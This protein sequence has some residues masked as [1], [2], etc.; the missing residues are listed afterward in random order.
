[1]KG[2][3]VRSPSNPHHTSPPH[4]FGRVS[5][6]PPG[7]DIVPRPDGT[8]LLRP[9][10]PDKLPPDEKKS[11]PCHCRKK[12]DLHAE[13][14]HVS[15]FHGQWTHP[16]VSS[17]MRTRS[18]RPFKTTV[19]TRSGARS[20]RATSRVFPVTDTSS[21][22]S[23]CPLVVSGAGT[24]PTRAGDSASGSFRS[25]RK[26]SRTTKRGSPRWWATRPAGTR[27]PRRMA[28]TASAL[29]G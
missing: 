27:P 11:G 18:A 3:A 24:V 6:H 15:S 25:S 9:A 14:C 2:L 20:R 28:T 22:R 23:T 17:G 13:Q 29:F 16:P 4:G 10:R 7:W 26:R 19:V 1:M 21:T 8:S 12:E 5:L